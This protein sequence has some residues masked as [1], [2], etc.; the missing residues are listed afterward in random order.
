[1]EKMT[2]FFHFLAYFAKQIHKM[3]KI[4]SI[5]YD[6]RKFLTKFFWSHGT[7]LGSSGSGSQEALHPGFSRFQ[8]PVIWAQY[9]NPKLWPCH[10]QA[11]TQKTAGAWCDIQA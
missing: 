8:I 7:P 11:K 5:F 4:T 1:M 9:D 2:C 6:M 3:H 10:G